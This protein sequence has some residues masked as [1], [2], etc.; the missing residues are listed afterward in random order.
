MAC[1][2]DVEPERVIAQAQ[3]LGRN[4]MSIRGI[5]FSAPGVNRAQGRR[6]T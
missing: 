2:D 6:W 5:P 4:P 1:H 3:R